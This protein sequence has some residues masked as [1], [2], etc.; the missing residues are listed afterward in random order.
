M[1]NSR[2]F[3]ISGPLHVW[4]TIPRL[5]DGEFFMFAAQGVSNVGVGG[6]LHRG[7]WLVRGFWGKASDGW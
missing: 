2:Q 7:L 1:L 3:R 5:A 6:A 4:L